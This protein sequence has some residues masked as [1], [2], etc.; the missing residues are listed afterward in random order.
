MTYV[1]LPP[2]A[3][4]REAAAPRPTVTETPVP[5]PLALPVPDPVTLDVAP[6]AIT[7]V[8]VAVEGTGQGTGGGAGQ[9]SG[10]GGGSGTGTGTGT[11]S[12]DGPG[13]G[14]DGGYIVAAKLRGLIIAP[15]CVRGQLTV[16]FS[17]GADGRVAGVEVNPPPKDAGCRRDLV[18]RLRQYKFDPARTRDGQTV[19]STFKV[20]IEH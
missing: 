3:A 9:E 20:T 12:A 5:A 19:A 10:S 4:P 15:D 7:P 1:A 13:S 18:T 8:P 6:V 2:V 11:G 16:L 14:G 17:V